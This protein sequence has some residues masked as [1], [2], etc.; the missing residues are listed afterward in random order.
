M[1]SVA[2]L[3]RLKAWPSFATGKSSMD[4]PCRF[5]IPHIIAAPQ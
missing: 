5:F 1:N 3:L 2:L 4:F